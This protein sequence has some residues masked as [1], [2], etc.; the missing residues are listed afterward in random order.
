MRSREISINIA[1]LTYNFLGVVF[2]QTLSWIYHVIHKLHFQMEQPLFLKQE[3]I[4]RSR[5]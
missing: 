1:N 3:E 5:H 4:F 2:D